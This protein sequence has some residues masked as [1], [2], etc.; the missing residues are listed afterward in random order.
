M[1]FSYMHFFNKLKPSDPI[2]GKSFR[3]FFIFWLLILV[4]SAVSFAGEAP[5]YMGAKALKDK[6]QIPREN[7]NYVLELL[8]GQVF[9]GWWY[10]WTLAGPLSAQLQESPDVSWLSLSPTTFTSDTCSDVVDVKYSFIAPASP[11]TYTTTIIDQ[12]GNWPNQ[13]IT[14]F[15]TNNPIS[16]YIEF[17]QI[18]AGQSFVSYDSIY[19]TPFE[20]LGCLPEYYPPTPADVVYSLVPQVSWLSIQPSQ[21][22]VGPTDTF[23][24][25]ET[26]SN[27]T[28][29]N[30]SCYEVFTADYF[31]WPE[32]TQWNLTVLTDIGDHNRN[33]LAQKF[34]LL[35][36]YPNPFNPVTRI[37]YNLPRDSEVTLE[38][39]DAS[40]QH[41]S[42][43]VSGRKTAGLHGVPFYG[44]QLPSG[45]YYYRLQAGDFTQ[46]RKMVLLK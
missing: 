14:L 33:P 27:N 20:G 18:N 13:P 25:A 5:G 34:T 1:Y 9:D 2:P 6:P 10:F 38:I 4:P 12:N 26:F 24:V 43:L 8:P 29:G 46:H 28:P 23:V 7:F 39:F 32:F 30:Y 37:L 17:V 11:G 35:Q 36:N 19:F 15:V 42:T 44:T 16:A 21:M 41:I 45:V 40:G 31:S 22:T 3:H